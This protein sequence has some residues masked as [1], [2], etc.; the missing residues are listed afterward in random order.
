[1]VLEAFPEAADPALRYV[2]Y[3]HGR[4]VEEQGRAAVSPEHGPY[5]LDAILQALAQ[6]G[7]VVIGELRPKDADPELFA[8]RTTA[9]IAKLRAAG[10]PGERIT[11]VGASKGAVIAM[12]VSSRL[13]DSQ[14]GYVPMAGCNDSILERYPIRLHGRLLSIHEASDGIGG[15]CR[16]FFN[17]SPEVARREEL[18]LETGLGHG[19]LYRP[20]PEWVT[21]TLRWIEDRTLPRPTPTPTPPADIPVGPASHASKREQE[22]DRDKTP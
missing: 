11:V 17:R 20:L 16:R 21:P 22:K 3:L 12:L 5:Q 13:E 14:I 1:M 2:V 7:T 4:I 15:S 19:F 8:E 6:P 18:R 10:V 9:A